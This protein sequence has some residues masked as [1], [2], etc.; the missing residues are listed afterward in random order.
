MKNRIFC[1]ITLVAS[2]WLSSPTYADER[3][4]CRDESNWYIGASGMGVLPNQ[5]SLDE[6]TPTFGQQ[7][8]DLK[9]GIGFSGLAGY[10]FYPNASIELE[11][12][13]Q[14]SSMD[15]STI[16][17]VA[18]NNGKG[19]QRN[20]A[21]M[22][23][24]RWIYR[25]MGSIA[26]YVAAGGGM[27][28]IRAPFAEVITVGPSTESQKVSDTVLAYQFM[29]GVNFAVPNSKFEFFGG[30]RYVGTQQGEVKFTIIP[31]YSQK[32][33]ASSHNIE[34]GGRMRF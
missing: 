32:F 3:P 20:Q 22:I 30:Y 19:A 10:Q 15:K 6:N 9:T 25:N 12:I 4:C 5:V 1:S 7:S 27:M 13:A 26:P 8:Y 28:K 21:I 34:I 23:N 29:A 18:G 33:D 2:L 16:A 14:Q 11:V 24:H 17:S 31:G